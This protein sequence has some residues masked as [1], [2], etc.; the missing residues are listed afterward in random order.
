MNLD[1]GVLKDLDFQKGEGLIP[2]VAQDYVSKEVVMLAYMNEEALRETLRTG[3]AHYWSR[4]RMRLWR[5]GETSGNTQRV[6]A[7]YYDCDG[8]ALL[9]LVDQKG[10]ACHTGNRTCFYREIPLGQS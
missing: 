9:L 2:V 7:V 10:Y 5:K 6:K 3:Y 1:R 8:D 4:S